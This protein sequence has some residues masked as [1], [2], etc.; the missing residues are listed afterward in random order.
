MPRYRVRMPLIDYWKLE[1][2][3]LVP[4]LQPGEHVLAYTAT[5]VP[6]TGEAQRWDAA[7]DREPTPSAGD[8]LADVVNRALTGALISPR[9][10]DK[11]FSAPAAG[12][13][14]S[15]AI[16]LLDEIRGD[17]RTSGLDLMLAVTDVRVLFLVPDGDRMDS[18]LRLV[19]D[20]PR[21]V[22][23]SAEVRSKPWKLSFGR[24]RLVFRDGSWIELTGGP[25]MGRARAVDARDAILAGS[26][27]VTGEP[28]VPPIVG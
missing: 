17:Y 10:A 28:G 25:T 5:G 21:A 1:G 19:A 2:Q 6:P 18:P 3:R 27:S 4:H 23:A 13:A 26:A 22:V 14:S 9:H 20:L 8:R 16:R 12:N 7:D 24:L 15:V 11:L